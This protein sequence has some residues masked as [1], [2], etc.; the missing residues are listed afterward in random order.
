M[1]WT[2]KI[3]IIALSAAGLSGGGALLSRDPHPVVNMAEV[4][5][6][7]VAGPQHDLTPLQSIDG[8]DFDADGAIVSAR[9]DGLEQPASAAPQKADAPIS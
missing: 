9:I 1:I 2:T 6:T 7:A 4:Q 8:I 5:Q 3:A